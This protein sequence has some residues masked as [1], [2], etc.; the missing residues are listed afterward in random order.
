MKTDIEIYNEVL[1][2]AMKEHLISS[3]EVTNIIV[4]KYALSL[5]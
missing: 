3:F 5:E 2:F 4:E 1:A